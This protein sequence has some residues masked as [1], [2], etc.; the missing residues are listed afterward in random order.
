MFKVI[1]VADFL[2]RL[3]IFRKQNIED[4]TVLNYFDELEVHPEHVGKNFCS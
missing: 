3:D 2:E 4:T 1:V